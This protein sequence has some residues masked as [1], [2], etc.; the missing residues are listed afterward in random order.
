[1]KIIAISDLHGH[2]I[3]IAPCDVLCIAGDICPAHNHN[4]SYQREWVRAPFCD[5]IKKIPAKHVIV[6]AGNHDWVFDLNEREN[7]PSNKEAVLY[8]LKKTGK[9]SYLEDVSVVIDG[10]KFYG[11]PWQP[12]FYHWAFNLSEE[13]LNKK[14]ALIPEDVDVLIAHG[15]PKGYCDCVNQHGSV[16]VKV[17]HLGSEALYNH[18]K[19]VMPKYVAVGHIHT[20]S[21]LPQALIHDNKDAKIVNVSILDEAYHEF[22][23][24]F[25]FEINKE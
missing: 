21:H 17:E 9:C 20:G 16:G 24:P 4:I 13:D 5:W 23:N 2:L 1:M 25:E 12:I 8:A 3:D 6:V 19:R 22:F 11:T 15:P 14:F 10:V 18:I 7:K